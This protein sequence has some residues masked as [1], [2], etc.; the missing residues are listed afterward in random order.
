MLLDRLKVCSDLLCESQGAGVTEEARQH[1]VMHVREEIDH[2]LHLLWR[3]GLWTDTD[4]VEKTACNGHT[5]HVLTEPFLDGKPHGKPL[6]D[7]APTWLK[8]VLGVR[9]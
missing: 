3:S 9:V 1:R 7:D 5:Y 6:S 8:E 2:L 4:P